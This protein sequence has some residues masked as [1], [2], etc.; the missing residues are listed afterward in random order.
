M[1]SFLFKNWSVLRSASLVRSP[2][3]GEML[4]ESTR[5]V[6]QVM[7]MSLSP[8]L[9]S[10]QMEMKMLFKVTGPFKVGSRLKAQGTKGELVCR[11]SV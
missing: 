2:E 6:R 5:Q 3:V 7:S 9:F 1:P 4:G 8:R 10:S 11:G